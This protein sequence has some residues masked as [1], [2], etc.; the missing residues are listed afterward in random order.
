[1]LAQ[2]ATAPTEV[3]GVWQV[4]NA[5]NLLYIDQNQAQFLDASIVLT[6]DINWTGEPNWVPLGTSVGFTG[7][8]NGNGHAITGLTIND[9]TN[10][11]VGFIGQLAKPGTVENLTL[12]ETVSFTS[13]TSPPRGRHGRPDR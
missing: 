8:F 7:T 10:P 11:Y 5:A 9:T 2:G 12:Q 4:T 1:M 3:G 13:F 6:Q